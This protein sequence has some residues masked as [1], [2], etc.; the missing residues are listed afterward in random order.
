M[1]KN[2]NG[3]GKKEGGRRKIVTKSNISPIEMEGKMGSFSTL[4]P[5]LE[6][7]QR[8]RSRF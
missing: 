7:W 1:G 3:E 5:F 8:G 6:K 2:G 4:S